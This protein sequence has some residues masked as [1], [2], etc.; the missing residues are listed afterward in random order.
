MSMQAFCEAQYLSVLDEQRHAPVP[1]KLA[2]QI[3]VGLHA[4]SHAPQCS[5]LE[6]V[7]IHAPA[8][9]QYCCPV[10]GQRHCPLW[11]TSVALQEMP[12]LPQLFTSVE[13]FT[14]TP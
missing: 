13:K 14:H 4:I 8:D 6:R 2:E 7:S 9:A 12:Q 10:S 5:V 1:V 11:Q 3:S